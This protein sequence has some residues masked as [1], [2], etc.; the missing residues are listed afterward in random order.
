MKIYRF[1]LRHDKGETTVEVRA[2]NLDEAK[3]L[4]MEIEQ[5]PGLAITWISV[6]PTQKQINKTK[7]L[8]RGI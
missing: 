8:L 6:V 5:C 4:A 3:K 7:N 1:G 2:S